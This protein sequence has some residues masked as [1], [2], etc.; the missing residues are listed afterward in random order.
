MVKQELGVSPNRARCVGPSADSSHPTTLGDLD[1]LGQLDIR[2]SRHHQRRTLQGLGGF[3]LRG[4]SLGETGC[5]H[6]DLPKAG[7][8]RFS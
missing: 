8:A 7:E 3:I 6:G 4:G 5:W 1:I 2:P